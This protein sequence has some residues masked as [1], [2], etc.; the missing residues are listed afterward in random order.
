[1]ILPSS[2]TCK[3]ISFKVLL[4]VKLE[5]L[6]LSELAFCALDCAHVGKF[7]VEILILFIFCSF[8]GMLIFYIPYVYDLC[9]CALSKMELIEPLMTIYYY[10][11]ITIPAIVMV[12]EGIN[13]QGT[14]QDAKH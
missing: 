7:L 10:F 11:I 4:E 12:V 1:M 9:F 3:A 8:L 5:T 14:L 13:M 2:F 6:Y